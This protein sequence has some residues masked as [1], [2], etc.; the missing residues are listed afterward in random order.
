MNEEIQYVAEN[1]GGGVALFFYQWRYLM[2]INMTIFMFYGVLMILPWM[3]GN[4]SSDGQ[5]K[6]WRYNATDGD[7]NWFE[8]D[9][10][11]LAHALA[12]IS[13]AKVGSTFIAD[14][15]FFYSGYPGPYQKSFNAQ[16]LRFNPPVN[17]SGGGYPNMKHADWAAGI[18]LIQTYWMDAAYVGCA[19]ATVLVF[20]LMIFFRINDNYGA[21]KVILSQFQFTLR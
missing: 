21:R 1:F 14:S 11:T 19:L 5:V 8:R 18:P 2:T 17:G 3:L 6:N 16:S 15:F 10:A 13:G 20:G 9:D 7:K 12:D 4:L